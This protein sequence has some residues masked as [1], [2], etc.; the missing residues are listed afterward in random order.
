[1]DGKKICMVR[2]TVSDNFSTTLDG[3]SKVT[4]AINWDFTGVTRS[5]LQQWAMSNRRI[6]FQR[7]IRGLSIEAV[8]AMNGKTIHALSA[9]RKPVD[10]TKVVNELKAQLP[11]E[12]AALL[13]AASKLSPEQLKAIMNVVNE[14]QGQAVQG[15]G[16]ATQ[17]TQGVSE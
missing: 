9:G 15:E 4:L 17:A 7:A 16:Q 14:G 5:Q 3:G 2:D 1:M 11:P 13:D 10:Q 8:K 6:A 12:Q